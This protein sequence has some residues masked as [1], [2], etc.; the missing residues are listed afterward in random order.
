[1]TT[2]NLNLQV[3]ASARVG[4]NHQIA[5]QIEA[6][7]KSGELLPAE[8]LPPEQVLASDLNVSRDVVRRAYAILKNSGFIE[9]QKRD[10]WHVVQN[11]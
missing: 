6:L 7:I 8:K 9:S 4:M 1:M 11:D 3:D 2:N 10:G 5:D